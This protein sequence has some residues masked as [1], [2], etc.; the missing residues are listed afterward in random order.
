MTSAHTGTDAALEELIERIRPQLH[1]YCAR[2][3]GSVIDGEDVLQDALMKAFSALERGDT[4]RGFESWLFRIAHNTALDFLRRRT[5]VESIQVVHG[6]DEIPDPRSLLEERELVA[7]S[8]RTFM[9]LPTAQRSA[10]ILMDVLGYSL[11]EIGTILDASVAAVKS[12]LHRG[13]ERLAQLAREPEDAVPTK[14]D[15]AKQSLLS[16]YIERFNSRD[17]DA[18]RRMLAEEVQLDLVN[19]ARMRGKAEVSHYFSNYG[20]A[21]GWRLQAGSVEGRPA[22]LVYEGN[23]PLVPVYFVLLEFTN[24]GLAT[25]RDFRYARYAFDGAE[26]KGFG[27]P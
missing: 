27:H 8:L 16:A 19:K 5:R 17:F 23:D 20:E 25:I 15:S 4:V 13:R 2:M 7:T 26:G 21:T 10:V 22:A 12:S 24:E 18:I 9:R 11:Q 1:R 6:L 3:T 14:L